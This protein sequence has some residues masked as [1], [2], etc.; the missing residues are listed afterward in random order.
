MSQDALSPAA[1]SSVMAVVNAVCNFSSVGAVATSG[2]S[3]SGSNSSSSSS[4]VSLTA[5]ASLASNVGV[6]QTILSIVS[7]MTVARAESS[8]A[9][10]HGNEIRLTRTCES[11][12]VSME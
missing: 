6:S 3:S 1:V 11:W 10:S 5:S 7:K 12:I 9:A 8:V 4:V 2:N